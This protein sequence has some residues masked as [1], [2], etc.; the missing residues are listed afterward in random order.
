MSL[1]VG[2]QRI[3]DTIAGAIQTRDPR[4]AGMF[5][6]FTRLTRSEPMPAREVITE[7][8]LHR[9]VVRLIWAIAPRHRLRALVIIPV[10]VGAFVSLIV[11]GPVNASPPCG[12]GRDGRTF[13][14]L[15]GR[16][17]GCTGRAGAGTGTAGLP[18]R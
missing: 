13:V 1:P 15:A 8:R 16:F 3:L 7:S 14:E 11:L 17:G 10:A 9:A 12:H 18:A 2:Q 6:I 5:A 4:L